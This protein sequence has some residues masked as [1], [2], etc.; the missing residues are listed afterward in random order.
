M[1]GPPVFPSLQS[2]RVGADWLAD[3]V[4][5]FRIII[6]RCIWNRQI[7]TEAVSSFNRKA[8][9]TR[10]SELRSCVKVEVAS[11]ASVANKPM[12]SVDVK[13]HSTSSTRDPFEIRSGGPPQ[14][15]TSTESIRLIK[16]GRMEVGE[17]GDNV[18]LA[19]HCHH[20]DDPCI[21]MDSDE[22]HFNV[23][24]CEGRS[25]RTVSTDHDL[26]EEKGEPKPDRAEAFLLTSLMPYR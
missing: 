9:L 20:Q 5:P 13:Q 14:C 6:A 15:F 12:V 23:S 17:E 3:A 24:Y 7:E 18:P 25:H 11:W 4:R 2:K 26:S 16:D 21:K 8:L 1:L 19:I 22:S 10:D